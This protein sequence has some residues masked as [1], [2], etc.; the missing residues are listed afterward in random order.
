MYLQLVHNFLEIIG[1]NFPCDNV[2]HF[3]TDG[4]DLAVLGITG[5]LHLVLS[6]L[7][8]PNTKHSHEVAVC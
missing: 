7:C 1:G 6:L 4:F 5:F 2:N 3:L 8:E